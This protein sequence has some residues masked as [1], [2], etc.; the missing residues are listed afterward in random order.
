MDAETATEEPELQGSIH[1]IDASFYDA[2]YYLSGKQTGKSNYVNYRWMPE[3]TGLLADNIISRFALKNGDKVLDYGCARGYLV[4]ALRDRGID[5]FGYDHSSWAI[6]HCHP[7]I[8]QFVT[9]QWGCV[10]NDFKLI[11]AKDVFEHI[12][13]RDLTPTVTML[14]RRC[15]NMAVLVPLTRQED[16]PYI[17][18]SDESDSSHVNRHTFGGW[19]NRLADCIQHMRIKIGT[20]DCSDIKPNTLDFPGSCGFFWLT[21]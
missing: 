6:K 11:W 18:P 10:G 7:D 20:T 19:A 2:D 17:Y 1:K 3:E 13:W 21:R 14:S 9:R 16:G 8:W 15:D 5:A 4:K 12:E